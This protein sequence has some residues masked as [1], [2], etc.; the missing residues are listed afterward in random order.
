MCIRDRD[1]VAAKAKK[2]RGGGPGDAA[3]S[4]ARAGKGK[5]KQREGRRADPDGDWTPSSR[6]RKSPAAAKA[7]PAARLPSSTRPSPAD[8]SASIATPLRAQGALA[9]T[10]EQPDSEYVNDSE[11]GRDGSV[12]ADSGDDSGGEESRARR[13]ACGTGQPEGRPGATDA[14]RAPSDDGADEDGVAEGDGGRQDLSLI[15]I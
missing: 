9:G 7:P 5:K 1:G 8:A 10:H 6:V 11:E 4:M 12:S 14:V 15:H 13:E 2:N 3:L